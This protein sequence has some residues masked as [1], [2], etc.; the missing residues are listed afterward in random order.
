MRPMVTRAECLNCHA[1]QAGFVGKIRGGVGISV[2][3]EPLY[4]PSAA[5]TCGRCGCSGPCG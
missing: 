1:E 5:A 2:P 3:L 4:V